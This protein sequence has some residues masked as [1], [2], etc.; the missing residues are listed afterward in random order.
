MADST[1]RAGPSN[2]ESSWW[3]SI[4]SKITSEPRSRNYGHGDADEDEPL[5]PSR[6]G[7]RQRVRI[8]WEQIAA[9]MM[10]LALGMIVGGFIGRRYPSQGGGK[11]HGPM[12]AP[13]WTL[14]P[15]CRGDRYADDMRG[16]KKL[17]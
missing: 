14:P 3:T 13:V 1:Q 7:K 4:K 16:F 5:L 15:V 17:T 11:D 12:V 6:L 8:G 10:I 2:T 9:Y